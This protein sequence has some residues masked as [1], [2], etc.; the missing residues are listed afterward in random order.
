METDTEHKIGAFLGARHAEFRAVNPDDAVMR[1]INKFTLSPLKREDVAVFTMDLANDQVD[2]HFSRFP[3]RELKRITQMIVGKPLMELHDM[4]GRLPRG[5][6]FNAEFVKEAGSAKARPD[7]YIL[8][9]PQNE[10]FIAHILGGVYRGTS[11]GFN[12]D[13]AEC[14]ICHDQMG[15]PDSTCRHWPG[16][17]Y[18]GEVCHYIMHGVNDVYEGSVVPLGSQS[19][20][21]VAARGAENRGTPF[22]QQ[23]CTTRGVESAPKV[24]TED[25]EERDSTQDVAEQVEEPK[26][27]R[28]S[29]KALV[30]EINAL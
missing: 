28:E 19:T 11:I 7:V 2:R 24:S 18:D 27:T 4:R 6:F 21:F 8:R 23:L 12:F 22:E 10:E 3:E 16:E 15:T 20:E 17:K 9:T 5:T 14:S 29:F 25:T 30:A 1:K 13:K 26:M